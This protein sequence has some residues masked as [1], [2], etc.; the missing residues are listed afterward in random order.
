MNLCNE[1]GGH[2]T[3][4]YNFSSAKGKQLENENSSSGHHNVF[5]TPT[6]LFVVFCF[7]FVFFLGM[8]ICQIAYLA[9]HRNEMKNK[10]L[11]K[12]T[13]TVKP[14]A[15]SFTRMGPTLGSASCM[16]PLF[17]QSLQPG[18]LPT[19]TYVNNIQI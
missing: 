7:C 11:P 6:L 14:W 15:M 13:H 9:Y 19:T 4:A 5:E 16:G 18:A 1:V 2:V 10:N 12:S 17:E 8:S 3:T